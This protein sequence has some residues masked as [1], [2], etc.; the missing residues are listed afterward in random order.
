[1]CHQIETKFPLARHPLTQ[2]KTDMPLAVY[3]TFLHL[4]T[5]IPYILLICIDIVLYELAM[6]YIHYLYHQIELI[7][8]Y[9]S[10]G[11]ISK[12]I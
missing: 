1:M 11:F 3:S 5:E 9:I 2:K 7:V 8:S 6:K 4:I 10:K 12:T